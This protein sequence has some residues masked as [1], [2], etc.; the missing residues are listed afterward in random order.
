M[1]ELTVAVLRGLRDELMRQGKRYPDDS[2]EQETF[3]D[4]GDA[5]GDVLDLLEAING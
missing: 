4:A 5:L 3:F 2:E 1:N